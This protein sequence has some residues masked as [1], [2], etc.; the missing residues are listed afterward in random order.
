[1]KKRLITTIAAGA[2]AALALA[3]CSAGAEADGAGPGNGDKTDLTIN[4]FSGWAEDVAVSNVWKEVLESKGYD[5]TLTTTTAG[6]GFTGLSQGNYD[7]NFDAWLPSTHKS[8][9]DKYGD[10]LE[11]LGAW[12]DKAPLTLAVNKDA[13]IDSIDQLAANADAFGNK[14]IGIEPGAGETA[15]VKDSV[16]P[17]YG[18]TKMDFVTSST[19]AM[20]AELKKDISNGDNVVVTLWKPHWAYN[21]FP[22]KD[23]KDPKGA[24]GEPDSINTIVRKGFT[25][26]YPALAKWFGSF[27]FPDDKLFDL[28]NKMFNSGADESEYPRIVKDWL[29]DNKDFADS[30]TK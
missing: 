21:E 8:Y 20:L 9:W 24:L 26:D 2:A 12:Y 27:S 22:L 29:A 1:M 17:Q 23:L 4:V 13:P 28:E 18:L 16:I 30:L 6:P 3:G 7:V 14:I 15:I 25:D 5:V 19:A 10:K 11:N